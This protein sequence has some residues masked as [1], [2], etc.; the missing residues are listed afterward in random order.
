LDQT[1]LHN[2]TVIFQKFK[3]QVNSQAA[4]NNRKG[5][6]DAIHIVAY[7][8]IDDSKDGPVVMSIC[9]PLK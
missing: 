5:F 7:H 3:E 6:V 2:D 1:Y 9:L 4:Y 8:S